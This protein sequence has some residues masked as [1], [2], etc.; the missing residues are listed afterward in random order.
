MGDDVDEKDEAV[1][2]RDLVTKPR[3]VVPSFAAAAAAAGGAAFIIPTGWRRWFRATMVSNREQV[4]MA[5][6]VMLR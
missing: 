3:I 5:P 1:E 4:I 6:D 2:G